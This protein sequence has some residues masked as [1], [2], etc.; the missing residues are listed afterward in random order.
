MLTSNNGMTAKES[1]DYYSS[2][3]PRE[4]Y[5]FA[6][7]EVSFWSGKGAAMLG[8]EGEVIKQDFDNVC[9]NK[10]PQDRT[11]LKPRQGENMKA[12]NDLTVGMPKWYSMARAFTKDETLK[13]ELTDILINAVKNTNGFMESMMQTRK[14]IGLATRDE[15]TDNAVFSN[16][17]QSTSRPVNGVAMMQDH[18]HMVIHNLTYVEEKNR[19][20]AAQ[21]GEIYKNRPL[22]EDYFHNELAKGLIAHN[23]PFTR[24]N[25]KAQ[26]L[27]ISREGVEAFSART[28]QIDA[29]C[30]ANNITDPKI[31]GELGAKLR[32]NKKNALPNDQLRAYWNELLS[33]ADRKAIDNIRN[34]DN[35][36]PP[37]SSEQALAFALEHHLENE[38][39]VGERQMLQTALKHG[40]GTVDFEEIRDAYHK[41][42]VL[43]VTGEKGEAL[44]TLKS[45]FNREQETNKIVREGRWSHPS[46]TEFDHAIPEFLSKKQK[47][48]IQGLWHS[49]NKVDL[50]KGLAGAGKT[51]T[52]KTFVDGIEEENRK[53]LATAPTLSATKNLAEDGF[54]HTVTTAKL[55]HSKELQ[56]E[57]QDQ[58]VLVDESGMLG[59]LDMHKLLVMSEEYNMRVVLVGDDKQ[60]S[61]VP[62]GEPFRLLQK[63]AGVEVY[64]LDEI[65]RQKSERYRKA[66]S[67]LSKGEAVYGFQQLDQMGVIKE[68]DDK[69]R[70]KALANDYVEAVTSGQSALI[71]SPTHVEKD[72]VTAEV[73][74]KL[75][76][77]GRIE[78]EGI[79]VNVHHQKHFS[80]AQKKDARYY[81]VGQKIEL[82]Q[83]VHG[84]SKGD[85][86]KVIGFADNALI[87]E[88]TIG[89][90]G[91]LRLANAKRFNLYEYKEKEFATGDTIRITKGGAS[92]IKGTKTRFD[93]NSRYKIEGYTKE[94]DFKLEGGRILSKEFGNIDHAIVTT[95]HSSQGQTVDNVFIAN[96]SKSFGLATNLKQFYVSASRGKFNIKVY[97]D[98]KQELL[99]QVQKTSERQTATELLEKGNGFWK[100]KMEEAIE[101]AR[102]TQ[103]AIERQM[104]DRDRDIN[105]SR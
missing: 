67:F 12:T 36:T 17:L 70:Y 62:R 100:S 1:I 47:D 59:E 16:Y 41:Y 37:I 28:A 93:A 91:D 101:M 105:P 54:R 102:R 49:T 88:N 11:K 42:G 79:I 8:L 7:T 18:V 25:G 22:I 52:I 14:H 2:S 6:D 53:V 56:E 45:I 60:H 55:L 82:N 90:V 87:V 3:L 99:K 92:A 38:S 96:S 103:A 33:D 15:F 98:D 76:E 40:I 43:Q 27:T 81:E 26:L 58:V 74:K 89:K 9:N 50:V 66:V 63:Y 77:V 80:T 29:F 71:V 21:L 32:E 64:E 44:T 10:H 65:R 19:F 46:H 104:Q 69:E 20:H 84:F 4:G 85:K 78:Q 72:L 97:T 31:K 57:Y 35:T 83:N 73:R 34:D 51:T 68:I 86:L 23:I 94:G 61:A 30:K 75:K 95:S 48:T 24:E 13:Q 5:Y 39:R